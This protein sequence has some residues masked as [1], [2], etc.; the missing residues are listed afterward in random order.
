MSFKHCLN[1]IVMSS[2]LSGI[3][4]IAIAEPLVPL[5]SMPDY[6]E[7]D[8]WGVALGAALEYEG[9]YEGSDNYGVEL[10]PNVTTQYRFGNHMIYQ[11]GVEIAW[12]GLLQD[13]WLM[14]AG[15]YY[16]DGIAPDDSD[17]GYLAGIEER[18]AVLSTF[19]ETKHAF[20]PLW[21]NWVAARVLT[22]PS[23]F[24][25]WTELTAGHHFSDS[26]DG[27]GTEAWLYYSYGN[28]DF[29]NRSF[30]VTAQDEAN[31]GLQETTLKGGFRS[32]GLYVMDRR[33]L[34]Q[35]LHLLLKLGYESYS[36][37]IQKS[38]IAKDDYK[39]EMGS[40]LVWQF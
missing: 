14:T 7:G 1:I 31:T 4:T 21:R 32:V 13:Q 37:E 8:G 35:N 23:D 33:R 12:R 18:D 10:D 40:V 22:G 24:G 36:S 25:W 9:A 38:P 11:E 20:D 2:C 15:I 27:T 28:T 29:F 17:D 5:P 16:E 3:Q 6:T 39:L 19:I 26:K 30:G 34:T